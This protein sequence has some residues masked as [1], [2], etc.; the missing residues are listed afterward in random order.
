MCEQ[1]DRQ[2]D[3]TIL[4]GAF[5]DYAKRLKLEFAEHARLGDIVLLRITRALESVLKGFKKL[6]LKH[7]HNVA[8]LC[9][10]T[11]DIQTSR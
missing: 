5:C 7:C 8:I 4:K 11:T 3:L 9:D 10:V 2:K 1:M 6:V